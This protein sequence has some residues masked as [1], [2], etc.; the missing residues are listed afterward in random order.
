[1]YSRLLSLY[2]FIHFLTESPNRSTSCLFFM[3]LSSTQEITWLSFPSVIPL[4]AIHQSAMLLFWY[5]MPNNFHAYIVRLV[6]QQVS[7]LLSVMVVLLPAVHFYLP[8]FDPVTAHLNLMKMWCFKAKSG[9]LLHPW[10]PFG[11]WSNFIVTPVKRI[12]RGNHLFHDCPHPIF[13]FGWLM[14]Q[15]A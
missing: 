13:C 9:A 10:R 4:T 2:L 14:T 3:M 15:G 1:M 8:S 6:H 12:F 7:L 11:V 5:L